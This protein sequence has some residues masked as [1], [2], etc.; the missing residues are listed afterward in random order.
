M[1]RRTIQRF[2]IWLALA[3]FTACKPKSQEMLVTYVQGDVFWPDLKPGTWKI[4][5]VQRCEIASRGSEPPDKRG[6]I[7]L[8]GEKTQLAWSQ[9]WLRGDIRNQ[10][11]D[12]ARK[13]PVRFSSTGHAADVGDSPW[14]ACRRTPETI[15]CE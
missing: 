11:Y 9:T 13:R 4:G 3:L 1:H 2:G 12:A 5:E 6:D 10:I 8:C 15:D 14:W 7:L